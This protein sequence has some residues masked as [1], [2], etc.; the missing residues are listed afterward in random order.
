[1]DLPDDDPPRAPSAAD[2]ELVALCRRLHPRL[3]GALAL[4][5]G[6]AQVGEDL[7]Q[8][9]LVRMWERWETVRRADSPEAW[10]FRVAFNLSASTWRRRALE[11]RTGP[12]EPEP[13][14]SDRTTAI[15]VRDALLTLPPRQR[16][17]VI[18]RYFA[19]L[20][21]RDAA[22]AM[23]CASGTVKALTSQALDR[24]RRHLTFA[25]ED[26]ED[27]RDHGDRDADDRD[28]DEGVPLHE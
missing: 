26:G 21:V 5:H 2:D 3:V 10:A 4:Q 28:K 22:D 16:A 15:A 8:E 6:S 13:V 25:T 9:T 17:A 24:L 20:S 19:D 14:E 23:G 18:L 7:A 11:R 1:M 12:P 27:D